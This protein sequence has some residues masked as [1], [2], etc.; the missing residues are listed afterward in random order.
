V[1]LRVVLAWAP[2]KEQ[3]LL[4]GMGTSFAPEMEFGP[5]LLLKKKAILTLI[6]PRPQRRDR[7]S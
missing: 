3:A 7:V 4:C 5:L 2:S 1:P 6:P